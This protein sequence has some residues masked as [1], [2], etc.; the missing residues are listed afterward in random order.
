M[1]PS[2]NDLHRDIGRMEAGLE[3]LK[4][5]VSE[6]FKGT[7]DRLDKVEQRLAALEGQESERKGAFRLGHW[8]VGAISGLVAF[9]AAHFLK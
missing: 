8:L 5:I 1:N 7:G 2:H 4:E 6:G 3:A 9:V